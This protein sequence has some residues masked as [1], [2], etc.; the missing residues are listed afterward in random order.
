MSQWGSPPGSITGTSVV[1]PRVALRVFPSQNQPRSFSTAGSVLFPPA[2][3]LSAAATA[4]G[5]SPVLD[6]ALCGHEQGGRV[7]LPPALGLALLPPDNQIHRERERAPYF[8]FFLLRLPDPA[9]WICAPGMWRASAGVPDIPGVGGKAA[10]YL[11]V[12]TPEQPVPAPRMLGQSLLFTLGLW[13]VFAPLPPAAKGGSPRI[14]PAVIQ[15]AASPH[16][17]QYVTAKRI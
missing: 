10:P 11:Q 7:R 9:P 14:L 6:N 8:F 12:R 5:S 3:C 13:S 2:R 1:G 15:S 16:P 17:V 4:C